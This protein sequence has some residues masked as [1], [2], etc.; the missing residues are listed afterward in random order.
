M[1][2]RLEHEIFLVRLN[3]HSF[4]ASGE[5]SNDNRPSEFQTANPF[6]KTALNSDIFAEDFLKLSFQPKSDSKKPQILLIVA[7]EP[8]MNVTGNGI[9]G[10]NQHATLL[11][12]K[13]Y[14][15]NFEIFSKHELSFLS[16]GTDGQDG[17]NESAGAVIDQNIAS[18]VMQ[19]AETKSNVETSIKN[20]DSYNFFD[21]L[22]KKLKAANKEWQNG[23]HIKCGHTG[24]NI[25]DLVFVSFKL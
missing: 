8:T 25:M 16:A 18:F 7:G 10:R 17:P 15:E 6:F 11:A 1:Y 12:L 5:D 14:T 9:G 19:S 3:L 21:C 13:T 4:F 24:T 20:C 23:A 22:D 2:Y